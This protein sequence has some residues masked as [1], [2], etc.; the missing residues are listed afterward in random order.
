MSD[1]KDNNESLLRSP[2]DS[3]SLVS[4]NVSELGPT[5]SV[6]DGGDGNLGAGWHAAGGSMGTAGVFG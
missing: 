6:S 5:D 1:T 4:D 2:R 3:S